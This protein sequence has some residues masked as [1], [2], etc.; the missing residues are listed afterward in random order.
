MF[1][2]CDNSVQVS[3]IPGCHRLMLVLADYPSLSCCI[4]SVTVRQNIPAIIP[5]YNVGRGSVNHY[6]VVVK[7]VVILC[8]QSKLAIISLQIACI[9][10]QKRI[11]IL[12]KSG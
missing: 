9:S 8:R 5:V 11:R 3:F 2:S 1:N 6:E 4:F 12:H 10:V 7:A